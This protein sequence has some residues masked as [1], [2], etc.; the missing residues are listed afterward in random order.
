MLEKKNYPSIVLDFFR[1]I[2]RVPGLFYNGDHFNRLLCFDRKIT[3]CQRRRRC[4]VID[5]ALLIILAV[6]WPPANPIFINLNVDALKIQFQRKSHR[7]TV[8]PPCRLC[9]ERCRRFQKYIVMKLYCFKKSKQPLQLSYDYFVSKW[10]LIFFS[11]KISMQNWDV[12]S[13][14]LTIKLTIAL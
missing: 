12:K 2:L 9:L 14:W 7:C 5:D 6:D 8:A 3:S 11:W 4:P 10:F 1:S 13:S